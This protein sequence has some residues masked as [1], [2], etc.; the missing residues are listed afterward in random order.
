LNGKE[1]TLGHTIPASS[2]FYRVRHF[3]STPV[4]WVFLGVAGIL[5]FL[6]L[7]PT[8]F[9]IYGSFTDSPLG[10]PG[11]FTFQNYVRAY[12]DPSAY[13]LVLNS[14]IFGHRFGGPFGRLGLGFSLDHDSHQRTLSEIIRAY[15][16]RSKYLAAD[17]HLHFL[18]HVA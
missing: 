7:Y 11:H 3:L 1:L 2:A 6:S 8:T 12:S 13:P 18:G 15:G 9:L 17:S 4:N 5:A 14:F 16:D 10:V